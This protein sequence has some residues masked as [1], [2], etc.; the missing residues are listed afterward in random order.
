MCDGLPT[1]IGRYTQVNIILV[2]CN[3][4]LV[5]SSCFGLSVSLT[6]VIVALPYG[7]L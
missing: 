3:E 2:L 6:A 4:V 1:A 7:E 5:A